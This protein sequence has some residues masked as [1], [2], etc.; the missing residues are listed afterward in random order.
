MLDFTSILEQAAA[1]SSKVARVVTT[2]EDT[3]TK[4]TTNTTTTTTTTTPPS[5]S[6]TVLDIPSLINLATGS[7]ISVLWELTQ[8][9]SL[10]LV[11]EWWPATL[12]PPSGQTHVMTD[13]ETS[14]SQTVPLRQISYDPNPNLGYPEPTVSDVAFLGDHLVYDLGEGN[15]TVFKRE[16]EDWSPAD[17][18][19]TEAPPPSTTAAGAPLDGAAGAAVTFGNGRDGIT[20]FVDNLYDSA[21]SKVSPQ[22][23]SLSAS[24]RL[25][26]AEVVARSKAKIVDAMCERL[27]GV[28][29]VTGEI[30]REIIEEV[31]EGVEGIKREV[32]GEK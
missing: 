18:D 27:E 10:D 23:S 21:F 20:A 8:A 9:D 3:T 22:F 5:P 1:A 29:V 32:F 13:E 26:V 24:R 14:D 28:D 12:L 2:E 15:T 19:L 4:T 16:G 30:V 6:S 11:K 17:V 25:A 31:G 7:R